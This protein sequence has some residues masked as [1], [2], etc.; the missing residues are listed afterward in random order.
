MPG[1]ISYPAYPSSGERRV[2]LSGEGYFKVTK[3]HKNPFFVTT[4]HATVKVL[5]TSF[6]MKAYPGEECDWF[7]TL[8]RV[9]LNFLQKKQ[10][11]HL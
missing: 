9:L 7:T 4:L 2:R 6:D 11:R 10:V 5:G 3:D 8:E 1:S